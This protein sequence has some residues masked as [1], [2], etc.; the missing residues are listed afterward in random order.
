MGWKST[1]TE[2]AKNWQKVQAE[3]RTANPG[4]N[5]KEMRKVWVEA[6]RPFVNKY[7]PVWWLR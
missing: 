6:F 2:N 5:D 3:L 1:N 7:E 4:L